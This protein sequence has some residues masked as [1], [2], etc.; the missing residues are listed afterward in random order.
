MKKLK[1]SRYYSKYTRRLLFKYRNSIVSNEGQVVRRLMMASPRLNFNPGSFFFRSIA[2]E[3]FFSI[4]F[5]GS[6]H[7][8]EDKKK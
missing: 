8:I 5:R 7:Q 2:T 6:Y 3:K 4:I 1:R